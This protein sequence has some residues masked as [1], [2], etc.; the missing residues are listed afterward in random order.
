MKRPALVLVL[1]LIFLEWLDFSL[2]LY[3]AKAVFAKQFFPSS[4]YSLT[5]SFALFAAAYVARPVGG[6]LFGSKADKTGRRKPMVYSAALMGFATLGICLLPGYA[7]LGI[8]A[9][10]GLLLLRMAQG[11]AL[12]GEIKTSGLFLIEHRPFSPLF[13]GSLAAA[14]GALGMFLG[15]VV[16]ALVQI[17]SDVSLWRIIFALVGMVSLW[18][19]HKRKQLQESPE[20]SQVTVASHN[21]VWHLHRRGLINIA[22]LGAYVSVAVYLCNVYWVS[23]ASDRHLWSNVHCAWL[24]SLAQ[25]ASACL[26][27]PIAYK[28]KAQYNKRLLQAS[29]VLISLAAPLLFYFTAHGMQGAALLALVGYVMTNALICSSLFYFLYLQLPVQYRCRGVSTT[30]AVAA[31]LGA[32]SL[33]VAEQLVTIQRYDWF[34]GLFVALIAMVSLGAISF[35]VPATKHSDSLVEV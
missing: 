9:T 27:L 6:W 35:T 4:H 14:S 32:L 1:S 34:P 5:L 31:T 15:G 33:P 2:Y 30:W 24:G 11:L 19:C 26:A 16:A 29:M 18:V 8:G 17:S 23:F 13:T 20:F 21:P 25:L 12:G 7:V 3:L 28:I 10:W 22:A